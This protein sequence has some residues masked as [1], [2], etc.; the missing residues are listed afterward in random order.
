VKPATERCQDSNE[1]QVEKGRG[2]EEEGLIAQPE[3]PSQDESNN[4][5]E[6]GRVAQ[7]FCAEGEVSSQANNSEE[8]EGGEEPRQHTAPT[9]P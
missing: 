4:G 7:G 9:I 6:G 8:L 3:K 5:K 1:Q 2:E